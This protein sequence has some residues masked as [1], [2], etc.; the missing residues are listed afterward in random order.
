[1]GCLSTERSAIA[2]VD[3]IFGAI[4]D[5]IDVARSATNGVAGSERERGADENDSRHFLEHGWSSLGLTAKV[6]LRFRNGSMVCRI[7]C[8]ARRTLAPC[9]LID[10]SVLFDY[11]T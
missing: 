4:C 9:A 5:R 11:D 10:A 1:M 6:T 2:S 3:R 8:G 7:R